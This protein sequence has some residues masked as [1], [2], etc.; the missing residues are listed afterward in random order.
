MQ[1][2]TARTL[3]PLGTVLIVVS[4]GALRLTPE[5]SALPREAEAS[6]SPNPAPAEPLTRAALRDLAQQDPVAFSRLCDERAESTIRDYRCT[7]HKQELLP[8]GM[9][10]VQEISVL[11]RVKPLSV[12]MTWVKNADR[13]RRALYIDAPQFRDANGEKVAKVEPAGVIAR[14]LVA[15]VVRPIHGDD[16]KLSS[17]RSMEDFGFNATL[18]LLLKINDAA[19]AR[20]ELD[21]RYVGEGEIDGR[22]T[23]IFQRFLPYTGPGGVYT[24]RKMIMHI[25][26]EW[27]VPTA[28]YSYA[29]VEGRQLLGSYVYTDVQLNPGLT[30]EDFRFWK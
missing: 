4:F 28:V 3:L 24:D 16:A 17:R 22:P 15:E 7:F 30:D 19:L 8:G 23:F 25:D 6:S 13:A 26:Q 5:T 1:L 2:H 20:G 29:D 9:S 11:C 21:Y 10:P 12:F 14:A 27:L 18:K